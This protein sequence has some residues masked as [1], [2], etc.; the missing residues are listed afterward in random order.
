[1][2]KGLIPVLIGAGQ[3]VDFWNGGANDGSP[4]SPLSLATKAS[5]RAL[6]DAGIAAKEID[7]IAVVRTMEDSI[8]GGPHPNGMNENP[9][10]ALAREIGAAPRTA[11]YSTI[12]GHVP[13]ALVNEMA[14]RI[15]DGDVEVALIAGAEAIRASKAAR[16]GD[17]ALDWAAG[18]DIDFE[19]RGMGE[20]LLSRAEIKHGL[21]FPPWI[22]A[23][24]ETAQAAKL[25]HGRTQHRAAMSRL[26]AGFS[27]VAAGNPYAQFPH[28]R[29]AEFLGEP[30]KENY[31]V[32]DPFLKWHVA[33]DAVNLGAAVL[34][35]SEEKADEL[36]VPKAQR[37]YLHGGGEASD[38]LISE[39]VDITGS[40][41]MG[42]AL[43][44]A[45]AQAGKMPEDVE[46]FDLYS[47]FPCAVTAA[48]KHLNIEPDAETRALT[49][50][51]GLP[52]FGGPGNNYS[53][54]AI[55]AMME[56]LRAM[57]DKIGLVL[58]NGGWMTKEAA[59]VYSG[60]RPDT[61]VP[62]APMLAAATKV[63]LD[64]EPTGGILETYTVIHNRDGPNAGIAFGR[65]ISGARFIAKAAPGAIATLR[66][67][68]SQVGGA[69]SVT[70][71]EEVSVFEFT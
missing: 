54:H 40:W 55:A 39:R 66:E 2:T 1:M 62:A 33:Q 35:V 17:V 69:V 3:C 67:D 11:I 19:D 45:L 58:A 15:H 41:A 8:P 23:L 5:T 14:G 53:L 44:R 18:V 4:P 22:Y 16:R 51:G 59:G 32:A 60:A 47:C 37:I 27:E 46:M 28:A 9:P 34:M 20:R 56:R 63:E 65:T 49:V 48:C 7:A 42:E 57:P 43:E 21:V 6:A 61:F 64:P 71:E 25:G 52:F 36:G 10:G 70:T 26:F 12:G 31:R 38:T 24:F 30:S 68:A 13:Q 50:T 29:S